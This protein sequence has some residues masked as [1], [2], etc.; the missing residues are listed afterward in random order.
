MATKKTTKAAA[1]ADAVETK[2]TKFALVNSKKFEGRRDLLNALL[3]NGK[4][5]TIAEVETAINNYLN[6]EV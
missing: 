1:K 3:D 5:Y 2:Y 4:M 6:K